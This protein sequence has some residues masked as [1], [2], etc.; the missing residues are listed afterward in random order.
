MC[1]LCYSGGLPE[2]AARHLLFCPKYQRFPWGPLITP[3]PNGTSGVKNGPGRDDLGWSCLL[4][5]LEA[6][7]LFRNPGMRT[8]LGVCI[9]L[10]CQQTF[11]IAPQIS[12]RASESTSAPA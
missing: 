1:Q 4:L 11:P 10:F 7:Q 6:L 8:Q 9:F 12:A 5:R 2:R 3:L